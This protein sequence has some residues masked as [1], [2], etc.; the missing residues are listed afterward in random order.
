MAVN[1]TEAPFHRSLRWIPGEG[2]DRL[3]V[4][5]RS[6]IAK[7]CKLPAESCPQSHRN[8]TIGSTLTA[9]RAGTQAA[10][11]AAAITTSTPAA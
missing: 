1:L 10:A 8:V 9:R 2:Q 6:Q 3:A 4:Q 11:S 5:N 7:T